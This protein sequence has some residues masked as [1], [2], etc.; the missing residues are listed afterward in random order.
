[1]MFPADEV[2]VWYADPDS[3]TNPTVLA[4]CHAVLS[5]EEKARHARFLVDRPRHEYLIAHA[6][7]RAVLSQYAPTP[8]EAWRFTVGPS[9]KPELCGPEGVPLLRFNLSHTRGLCACAVT[10]TQPV[11]VDV[12]TVARAVSEPLM[13]SCTS[14]EEAALV[15][16]ASLS[17]R[18]S[19]FL[20]LWTLKEAYLKARGVG[21]TVPTSAVS[22][23]L[24]PGA[25]ARVTFGPEVNDDPSAWQFHR[26]RPR[27]HYLAVAVRRSAG[28][29]FSVVVREYDSFAIL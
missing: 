27:S 16:R 11:G 23:Q 29:E 20:D 21:L 5:G 18:S 2:H 8:P 28:R 15:N 17:D 10:R 3:V 12:E 1:M 14:D 25:A 24:G 26:C 7:V 19:L 4:R 9:G 22:Y 6:L 13:A